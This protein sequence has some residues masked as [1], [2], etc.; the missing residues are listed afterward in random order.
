MRL[1]ELWTWLG[2]VG[3]ALRVYLASAISLRARPGKSQAGQIEK[4]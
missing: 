4:N 3:Q 2:C 1:D